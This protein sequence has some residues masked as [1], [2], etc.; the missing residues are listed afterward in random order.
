MAVV[1]RTRV[2]KIE[3]I[4]EAQ[5][6]THD[7][8]A[9]NLAI[10]RKCIPFVNV[11]LGS[12]WLSDASRADVVCCKASY[13]SFSLDIME[14]KIS[15]EDFL[16]DIRKKKWMDYLPHCNRFYF[17]V[18][19]GVCTKEDIPEEAGLLVYN[20]NTW[21][22][23][24]LAPKRDVD[25]P[26]ET[27]L[28]LIFARQRTSAHEKRIQEL[29]EIER[30]GLGAKPFM[31]KEYVSRIFGKKIAKL[32]GVIKK[33]G[34]IEDVTKILEEYLEEKRKKSKYQWL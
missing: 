10:A 21:T 32:L 18:K 29:R 23:A 33:I 28:S 31:G 2:K 8:L 13:T 26:K 1:R 4:K 5:P 16:S 34:S 20:G 11:H 24:K 30:Y 3:I 12:A 17:A 9:E 22:T 6:L 7:Q 15:R 19:K 25:I 14:V 27:F